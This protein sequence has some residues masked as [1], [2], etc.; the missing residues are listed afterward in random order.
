MGGEEQITEA[1]SNGAV[2]M[3]VGG[4]LPIYYFAP[5]ILLLRYALRL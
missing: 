3:Q 1:V 2:E 4:G 5:R